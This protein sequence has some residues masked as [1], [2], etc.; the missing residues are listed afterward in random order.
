VLRVLRRAVQGAVA[1]LRRKAE[2][3]K[4]W[5]PGFRADAP[6]AASAVADAGVDAGP[7]S[8]FTAAWFGDHPRHKY[9]LFE[10]STRKRGQA[11]MLVLLHGCHQDAVDFAAGTRMNEV[12]EEAGMVVLYPEQ[13][14][15][16]N[17]M[18]CWNWYTSKYPPDASDEA[19]LIA[20]MTRQVMREHD[21]DPARVYVAGM[22]AGGAL[23]SVLARTYPELYAAVGVHSG[24]PAGFAHDL[25]SAM[26]LMFKGP[27]DGAVEAELNRDELRRP[28]PS[29]VFHG[30]QDTTVHPSNGQAIHAAAGADQSPAVPVPA[31]TRPGSGQHD[32]TRS[33]D[34]GPG[35]V[36]KRELWIVHGAGHAWAGG[37][38]EGSYTDAD[39]PDASSEMLRFFLQHRLAAPAA[40]AVGN[41]RGEHDAQV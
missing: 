28:A 8:C 25:F 29:I 21:I 10:P 24:V 23:A 32:V 18:R 4:P 13:S 35:G 2:K 1:W 9:M 14:I 41:R 37:S 34:R 38:D 40:E 3:L 16:A 6:A 11:P 39:G 30:D 36:S 17:A 22:S 5:R 7:A 26:R 20:A 31:R 15:L 33:V 27:E 12:A 19:A